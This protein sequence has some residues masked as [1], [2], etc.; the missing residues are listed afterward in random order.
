MVLVH[1]YVNDGGDV[2]MDMGNV[3]L[4]E[5]ILCTGSKATSL[6]VPHNP[7]THKDEIHRVVKEKGFISEVCVIGN[8]FHVNLVNIG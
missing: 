3:G 5:A 2:M 4:G 7:A 1:L 8:C 6:V